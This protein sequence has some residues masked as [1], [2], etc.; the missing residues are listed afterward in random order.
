MSVS[1]TIPKDL[2]KTYTQKKCHS[3]L[4]LLP[5][6]RASD[7]SSATI[8]CRRPQFASV[9]VNLH[10]ILKI[11]TLTYPKTGKYKYKTHPEYIVII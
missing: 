4:Y 7:L 11:F 3:S 6:H 9:A 8:D 5:L 1:P 2:S 10:I